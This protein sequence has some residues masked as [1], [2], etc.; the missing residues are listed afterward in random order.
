MNESGNGNTA[1][2]IDGHEFEQLG[3]GILK[4]IEPYEISPREWMFNERHVGFQAILDISDEKNRVAF[5]STDGPSGLTLI[6]MYTDMKKKGS[7]VGY[8]EGAPNDLAMGEVYA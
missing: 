1:L 8:I 7:L 2:T 5:L 6:H 4:A 3:N